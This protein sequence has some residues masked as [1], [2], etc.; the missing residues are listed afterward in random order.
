MILSIQAGFVELDPNVSG[1]EDFKSVCLK[2]TAAQSIGQGNVEEHQ[3]AVGMMTTIG[4]FPKSTAK[5]Y[6]IIISAKVPI[7]VSGT[8]RKMSV[9]LKR[10][11]SIT[12]EKSMV[13]RSAKTH[14]SV[15]GTM[16][17]V[18]MRV[19][20][21]MIPARRFIM[22]GNVKVPPV[23]N[24]TSMS[25]SAFMRRKALSTMDVGKS[26]GKGGVKELI[27]VHGIMI[28]VFMRVSLK[29]M[30][31]GRSIMV[32]NA[33]VPPVVN[34]IS[35]NM[36]AFMRRKALLIMA[37]IRFMGQRGVIKPMDASGIMTKKSATLV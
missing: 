5:V 35:M 7:I 27:A 30:D 36:N 37:V 14:T 24:G 17:S 4:A 3:I 9:F 23:V 19:S 34:G 31:A 8:L 26:M 2:M 11:L 20:S 15:N 10:V 32:G 1:V 33:K 25:V 29:M 28:S 21:K 6:M 22:V 12:V 18:F 16:I 13:H